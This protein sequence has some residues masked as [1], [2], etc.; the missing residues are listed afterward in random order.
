VNGPCVGAGMSL[1]M[2]CDLIFAARS[3]SFSQAFVNIGLVPDAGSSYFLPRLIGPARAARMALLA[4]NI[5]AEEAE[6]WGLVSFVV[7]DDSL[8]D[9]AMATARK[10]AKGPTRSIAAI[11]QMIRAS[12]GNSLSEQLEMERTHQQQA[13]YSEDFAE[14]VKAFLEKRKPVFK[15]K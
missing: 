7:D 9:N 1:A 11:C 13:G 8:F 5:T 14:G 3:A 10:L 4:D 12:S 15:G 6:R 2:A